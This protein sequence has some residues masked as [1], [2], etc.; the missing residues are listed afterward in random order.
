MVGLQVNARSRAALQRERIRRERL[1]EDFL[2]RMVGND[3]CWEWR[4]ACDSEGYGRIVIEG[5]MGRVHRI[6]WEAFNGP[7]PAGLLALHRCDNPPCCNPDHLFI[8]TQ[9]QNL[10][11]MR[12]KGRDRTDGL[13]QNRRAVRPLRASA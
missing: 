12:A 8:G 9:Q 2:A 7:I 4:G 11:D 10:A 3:G 13:A 5:R 1:V 6:V